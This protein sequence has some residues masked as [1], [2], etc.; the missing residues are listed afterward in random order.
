LWN[1]ETIDDIAELARRSGS[2][3]H[4][5]VGPSMSSF[6]YYLPPFNIFLPSISSSLQYFPSFN[7]FLPSIFSFLRS[8]PSFNIFLPS[9]PSFLQY[10]PTY[11]IS[12]FLQYFPT[13]NTFLPSIFPYLQDH[14]SDG[15]SVL[16]VVVVVVMVGRVVVDRGG[17]GVVVTPL[18]Y[19]LPS[20]CSSLHPFVLPFRPSLS[21][22]LPTKNQGLIY[23]MDFSY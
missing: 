20:V 11:N 14:P 2:G 8:L 4:Q 5:Q 7:I 18:P 15:L 22:F 16:M 13:F 1:D 17:V 23:S 9:I 3:D 6:L 21:S 19:L 10:F 12:S